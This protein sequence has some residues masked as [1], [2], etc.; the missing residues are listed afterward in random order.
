MGSTHLTVAEVPPIEAICTAVG[1]AQVGRVVAVTVVD[2]DQT[3][4]EIA[5]AGRLAAELGADFRVRP[6]G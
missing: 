4:E 2:Y 6:F 5:A 1:G 3:R